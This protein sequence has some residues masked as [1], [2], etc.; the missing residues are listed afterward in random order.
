MSLLNF[1]DIAKVFE[2]LEISL[3]ASLKRNLKRHKAEEA[4]YGRNWPAWQ[5]EKLRNMSTFRKE[6]QKILSGYSSMIDNETIQLMQE[7]FTEG[8][9][10]VD[11]VVANTDIPTSI[12]DAHFFG[13]NDNKMN[14]L[15]SDITQLEKKCETAAVR[16]TDDVYRTVLNKVQLSMSTGSMT[17]T[18]AIDSAVKEFLERGINCIQYADGKRVNV[19]DYARMAL[20]TTSTRAML[21]GEAKRRYELGID[22]VMTSQYGGCSETCLPWQGRVYIDDV[23]TEWNGETTGERGKSNYCDKWFPLLSFAIKKGLF[24]PNCRHTLLTYIDGVTKLP[25]PIPADKI[26][27]QRSLEQKQRLMERKI[28]RLKRLAAGTLNPDT[29]KTYRKQLRTAQGELKTFVDKNANVL[30]RDYSREKYYGDLPVENIK[31]SSEI[32]FNRVNNAPKIDKA[33]AKELQ[34]EYDRF[35][36]MFGELPNLRNVEIAPYMN[37]KIFGGFNPNSGIITL[38][39]VGGKDGKSFITAIALDEFKRGQWSTPSPYHSFYHELAHALQQRMAEN[40]IEWLVKLD[41]IKDIESSL[42]N[43]LTKYSDSD[44][45]KI[46]KQELSI[47]GFSDTKEFISESIAEYLNNP[48]KARPIA[49]KVVEIILR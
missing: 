46:A 29:A 20:R 38:N 32:T 31:G 23:F 17:L 28:R 34:N 25:E 36:K 12:P 7:Q 15:M 6:N 26:K 35:T 16:M 45:I 43:D 41:E 9:R 27:K 4:D 14:A 5:T 2:Q 24:H 11:K 37:N 39:G 42:F 18:Q 8:E 49:K 33:F 21:Q 44:K 10:N 3:M 40:D 22:T 47:Y 48:K 19:A 13:V 30:H 1:S